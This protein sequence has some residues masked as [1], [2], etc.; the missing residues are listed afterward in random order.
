MK[1]SLFFDMLMTEE[2]HI[3][4]TKKSFRARIKE[5]VWVR[6]GI[7]AVA[8]G[9]FVG[10]A[11][12]AGYFYRA[13]K[14]TL[15]E[16]DSL[17]SQLSEETP[18]VSEVEGVVASVAKLIEL[19][20]GETPTLA[21]V[22]DKSKLGDQPFFKRAENGDK[23]LIYTNAARAI[24]YRP[25]AGRVIDMT[26]VNTA[27]NEKSN[28]TNSVK[29]DSDPREVGTVAGEQTISEE[30][31]S[32][33]ESTTSEKKTDEQS[34]SV[35]IVNG[36]ETAGLAKKTGEMVKENFALSIITK[37]SD[38]EKKDYAKTIVSDVSGRFPNEAKR[39]AEFLNGE[40]EMVPESEIIPEGTDIFV[41]VG[42]N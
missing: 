34:F 22:S 27:P 31:K 11:S 40:V 18:E 16:K 42:K 19:P 4:E 9:L 14:R 5:S 38:A 36:T 10:V 17:L 35:A 20:T 28:E 8:V 26:A 30:T 29:A 39:L 7:A 6:L 13:Y 21:T 37:T 25:S 15:S 1:A 33:I 24:L 2:A 23:V 3:S 41:V 12:G 32:S